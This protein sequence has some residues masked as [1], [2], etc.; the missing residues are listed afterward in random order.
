MGQHFL[1]VH[2][3]PADG[4]DIEH[5]DTCKQDAC[6]VAAMQEEY[7]LDLF[8]ARTPEPHP[9]LGV[10][11]VVASGRH[12]VEYWLRKITLPPHIGGVEYDH[13]LTIPAAVDGAA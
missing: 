7:G 6:A 5:P 2:D 4:M 1:I 3:E 9:F 12:L 10:R 11:D 8:F 13:G